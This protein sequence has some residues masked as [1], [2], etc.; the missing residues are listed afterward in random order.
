MKTFKQIITEA[1]LKVSARA[2]GTIEH[3]F[4]DPIT[5]K[6]I[7]TRHHKTRPTYAVKQLKSQNEDAKL[8]DTERAD[9]AAIDENSV[10]GAGEKHT[11]HPLHNIV[12]QHG[13]KWND[14]TKG[15]KNPKHEYS[16]NKNHFLHLT[17]IDKK[18][19]YD[20]YKKHPGGVKHL[21]TGY[22]EKVLKHHLSEAYNAFPGNDTKDD[23]DDQTAKAEIRII[24]KKGQRFLMEPKAGTGTPNDYAPN[25]YGPGVAP[26]LGVMPESNDQIQPHASYGKVPTVMPEDNKQPED[27]LKTHG[28][29]HTMNFS[30]DRHVYTHP[31][32][33]DHEIHVNRNSG[34]WH[35]FDSSGE[36]V[37]AG[38]TH[39][40]LHSHLSRF[41]GL[42][43]G[44]AD[45]SNHPWHDIAIN[46]GFKHDRSSSALGA[47]HH[48]YTK[49]HHELHLKTSTSGSPSWQQGAKS[50]TDNTP[51]K[52]HLSTLKEDFSGDSGLQK[53]T[54]IKLPTIK[55]PKLH[56]FMSKTKSNH[57]HPGPIN[58]GGH[59]MKEDAEYYKGG[60][61]HKY[62][63]ASHPVA[64]HF[65]KHVAIAAKH[66]YTVKHSDDK[67]VELQHP[68]KH[69]IQLHHIKGKVSGKETHR[70]GYIHNAFGQYNSK[71]PEGI[72]LKDKLEKFHKTE[73]KEG[74]LDILRPKVRAQTDEPMYKSD[75]DDP[76]YKTSHRYTVGGEIEP[77]SIPEF[78][79]TVKKEDVRSPMNNSKPPV[80]PLPHIKEESKK[81]QY[82]KYGGPKGWRTGEQLLPKV[83]KLK[84]PAA[85][86]YKKF[87]TEPR[88][89]AE[90]P[91]N[92]DSKYGL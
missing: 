88:A 63:D 36:G 10:Y 72:S 73:M 27:A 76:A 17:H 1:G 46:S 75:K 32:H 4:I 19:M 74:F 14:T 2:S 6:L 7:V 11:Q 85:K 54:P 35:H 43:E 49:G 28:W 77:S 37:R 13:F 3:S 23:N 29:K 78:K 18:P 56:N 62:P 83:K 20:L 31:E 38:F 9:N 8:S 58:K 45:P 59:D 25:D 68:D 91:G 89:A 51:L 79:P 50:G 90:D 30:S 22:S 70:V 52:F 92:T 33:K 61:K 84:D 55:M 40:S 86:F 66:G 34:D 82:D 67:Y 5:G 47:A 65:K 16:D 80:K 87:H 81:D 69:S 24:P 44:F 64:D 48:V 39:D 60:E 12:T 26:G 42:T 15:T 21:V 71:Y 41:H 53:L 57:N